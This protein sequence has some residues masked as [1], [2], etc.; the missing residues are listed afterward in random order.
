M[1]EDAV[2]LFT[3]RFDFSVNILI[4]SVVRISQLIVDIDLV[5]FLFTMEPVQR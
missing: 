4:G 2:A 3:E 1:Q 5:N